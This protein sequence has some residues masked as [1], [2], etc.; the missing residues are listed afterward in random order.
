MK[1]E[2]IIRQTVENKL[3]ELL[4]GKIVKKDS[5]TG[6]PRFFINPEGNHQ[7]IDVKFDFYDESYDVGDDG[8]L[9]NEIR[10]HRTSI[11]VETLTKKQQSEHMIYLEDFIYEN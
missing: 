7:I 4:I 1:L 11:V 2:D 9:T 5:S 6:S 10:S 3:K 8:Y